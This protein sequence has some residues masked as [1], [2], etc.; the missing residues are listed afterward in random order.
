MSVKRSGEQLLPI[1]LLFVIC[2]LSILHHA[3]CSINVKNIYNFGNADNNGFNFYYPTSIG[4]PAEPNSYLSTLFFNGSES[5]RLTTGIQARDVSVKLQQIVPA[6]YSIYYILQYSNTT[7]SMPIN[8]TILVSGGNPKT[9]PPKIFTLPEPTYIYTEEGKNENPFI[10]GNRTVTKMVCLFSC[11]ILTSDGKVFIQEYLDTSNSM[12]PWTETFILNNYINQDDFQPYQNVEIVD[13]EICGYIYCQTYFALTNY[14]HVFSFGCGD[15]IRGVATAINSYVINQI[16]SLQNIVSLSGSKSSYSSGR[17]VMAAIDKDGKLYTW[18]SNY[19]G[20]MGV[21]DTSLDYTETPRQVTLLP[22]KVKKIHFGVSHALTILEN[23]NV[24]VF[25]DNDAQQCD[26]S[27]GQVVW[28]P[29][30]MS[31]I[32]SNVT[33]CY[34]SGLISACIIGGNLY[35]W[36]YG[37]QDNY[38]HDFYGP[39]FDKIVMMNGGNLTKVGFTDANGVSVTSEGMAYVW[40]T[41]RDGIL[42][43]G[44]EREIRY[45]RN[46]T[47]PS[48]N[49][50]NSVSIISAKSN[51]DCSVIIS[52]SNGNITSMEY[53]GLCSGLF[54][55]SI[56]PVKE[57]LISSNLT[58]QEIVSIELGNQVGF[59]LLSNGD[60]YGWGSPAYQFSLPITFTS[61]PQ[62]FYSNVEK[63][64]LIGDDNIFF[65]MKNGSVLGIGRNS[66]YQF[67]FGVNAPTVFNSFTM[68]DISFLGVGERVVDLKV[69]TYAATL[70]LLTNQ[71]NVYGC[72]NNDNS[73]YL[74]LSSETNIVNFIRVNGDVKVRQLVTGGTSSMLLIST[75]GKPYYFYGQ[76]YPIILPS[77]DSYVVS[78]YTM[79]KSYY[80]ITRKG[81]LYAGGVNDY[82]QTS[83]IRYRQP[84]IATPDLYPKLYDGIPY[85]VA[86][87]QT[88][89]SLYTRDEFSCFGY[90]STNALACSS[91]GY[92][93]APNSCV[94][95]EGYFG[96]ECE[97]QSCFRNFNSNG[98]QLLMSDVFC[99]KINKMWK[100]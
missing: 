44:E 74:S 54:P 96:K 76:P 15:Y 18:G 21:N 40:G 25:G 27:A 91:R 6:T 46:L 94:C 22:S 43:K 5:Y 49:I 67:G 20:S 72:G 71:G 89:V 23:G 81:N 30:K 2:F 3:S 62:L 13:I 8:Q 29:R 84:P 86:L 97:M 82:F 4:Y 1:G 11:L 64:A 90:N 85:L 68:L 73:K 26:P 83:P 31:Y 93:A 42:A 88:R 36:G 10:T 39:N 58:K 55:S 59:I 7:T 14:G 47:I 66:N 100:Q 35:S 45:P 28:V 56:L 78:G 75:I 34:A 9:S 80:L 19:R 77:D 98:N 60:L 24:Y 41:N 50:S 57:S 17:S 65:L 48:M 51:G 61:S 53:W 37:R 92:C 70:L 12:T 38:G 87:R 79:D 33:E 63:F 32:N 52:K 69:I 99:K 16:A 95:D